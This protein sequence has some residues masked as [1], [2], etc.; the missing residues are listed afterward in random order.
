MERTSIRKPRFFDLRQTLTCGQCFRYRFGEDGWAE[1]RAMDQCVRMREEGENLVLEAAREAAERFWVPYLDLDADYEAIR[2]TLLVD[3]GLRPCMEAGAGIRILRQ[4]PFEAL[5]CFIISQNNNI[6]R[7]Q[8]IVERLC[9]LCG[10][11]AGGGYA[12][13]APQTLAAMTVEDLAPIRSGFRARYIVD[14]AQKVASGEVDL[15]RVAAAPLEEAKEMLMKIKGVGAKV[16]DCALLFGFHRLGCFPVDVWIGRVM[17]E[18][19]P[20]GAAFLQSPYAGLAQQYLFFY[21]RNCHAL[22]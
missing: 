6:P 9:A 3:E 8:G 17:E 11:P 13:P 10:A 21:A 5:I 18:L 20:K 22:K 4:D 15:Q 14:A 1:I 2:E 12:F 16:A 19:F 7:I